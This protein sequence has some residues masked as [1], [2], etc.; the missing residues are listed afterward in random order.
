MSFAGFPTMLFFFLSHPPPPPPFFLFFLFFFFLLFP[1]FSNVTL[2]LS[3]VGCDFFDL[4]LCVDIFDMSY[5]TTS[6]AFLE[7]GEG[8]RRGRE[9][10]LF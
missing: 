5:K 4:S 1:F 10:T 9:N 7:T 6:R 3:L 8:Q 2:W